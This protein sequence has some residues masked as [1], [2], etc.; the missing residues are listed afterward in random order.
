M[1][2]SGQKPSATTGSEPDVQAL[3]PVV[4]EMEDPPDGRFHGASDVALDADG[5]LLLFT[6]SPGGV[7]VYAPDGAYLGKWETKQFVIAHG[8]TIG[9]DGRACLVDQGDH[10]AFVYADGEL[11]G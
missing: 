8:I 9:P 2:E 1:S 5:N 4:V 3:W 6:R 11:I 7:Y 10:A